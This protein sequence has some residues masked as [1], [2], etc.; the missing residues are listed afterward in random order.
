MTRCSNYPGPTVVYRA[1]RLI[2]IS[3][4]IVIF[5]V[6][7]LYSRIRSVG[8]WCTSDVDQNGP[9]ILLF[10]SRAVRTPAW[11]LRNRIEWIA[12]LKYRIKIKT[13][14]VLIKHTCCGRR[15]R[16]LRLQVTSLVV[17]LLSVVRPLR[18]QLRSHRSYAT[19]TA[20]LHKELTV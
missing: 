13:K 12:S 5:M 10:F 15:S 20:S 4:R 2:C 16:D 3:V 17:Y 18:Q 11:T 19:N 14:I 7:N 6:V 1:V 8:T 9:L